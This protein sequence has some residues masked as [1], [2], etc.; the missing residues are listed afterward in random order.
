MHAELVCLS[1]F[2]LAYRELREQRGDTLGI[3]NQY[4]EQF[5]FFQRLRFKKFLS[6]HSL[7]IILGSQNN[8]L[9]VFFCNFDEKNKKSR[10]YKSFKK[11]FPQ[12]PSSIPNDR[13]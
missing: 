3:Q 6:N 1:G 13:A 12:P 10:S 4:G 8:W 2:D 9:S 5:S 11:E 7:L